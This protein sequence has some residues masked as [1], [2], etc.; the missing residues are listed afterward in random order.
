MKKKALALLLAGSMLFGQNVYATDMASTEKN[1]DANITDITENMSETEHDSE[2]V[3]AN[4]AQVPDN[5]SDDEKL[6]IM[7]TLMEKD[8]YF[9]GKKFLYSLF[10]KFTF[11]M[12]R[13][14]M[15]MLWILK[16]DIHIRIRKLQD[17][18][19]RCEKREKLN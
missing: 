19:L 11:Q 8:T 4:D 16:K 13:L 18:I 14:Q 5:V 7:K 15:L 2:A 9:K 12:Y 10:A 1:T 17:M 6:D 3:I